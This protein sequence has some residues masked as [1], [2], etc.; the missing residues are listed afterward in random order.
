MTPPGPHDRGGV[1][2]AGSAMPNLPSRI[3]AQHA[4]PASVCGSRAGI[5]P[6]A[7]LTFS[8]RRRSCTRVVLCEMGESSRYGSEAS[9]GGQWV[10]AAEP[11]AFTLRAGSLR[12]GDA[13]CR[14][15]GLDT[16]HSFSGVRV[17]DECRRCSPV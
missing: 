5:L 11:D 9:W 17:V 2:R 10:G 16:S 8:L 14:G 4:S 1:K 6:E 12:L 15:A 13:G 7:T 3:T